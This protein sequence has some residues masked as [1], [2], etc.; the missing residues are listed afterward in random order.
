[1]G[2]GVGTGV[3]VG[4]GVGLGFAVGAAVAGTTIT[5]DALGG[6]VATAADGVGVDVP[7]LGIGGV[8]PHA[9]NKT[10]TATIPSVPRANPPSTG[11]VC[12]AV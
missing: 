7:A 6:G 3:G 2:T 8:E 1:M 10:A 5:P 4:I 11:E 12:H 9:T